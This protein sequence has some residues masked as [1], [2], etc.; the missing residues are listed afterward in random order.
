MK[1]AIC[2]L[3][4]STLLTLVCCEQSDILT[5][6]EPDAAL[7]LNSIGYNSQVWKARVTAVRGILDEG[8]VVG[9]KN[10]SVKIYENGMLMESLS[11]TDL[12]ND[13]ISGQP[14]VGTTK[15]KP[16]KTYKVV[17]EAPGYPSITSEF[18][19]PDSIPVDFFEVKELG[20][21]TDF[22]GGYPPGSTNM[23]FTVRFTDPPGENY[24]ELYAAGVGDSIY[25]DSFSTR[26]YYTF[27]LTFID[28]AYQR[29][30]ET[31][32][33]EVLAFDDSFFD[34]RSVQFELSTY[35]VN[36]E[37]GWSIPDNYTIYIRNL[38]KEYYQY[39][40]TT[41]LQR[42]TA[43][44]PYAQPVLIENNIKGGYGIFG[45]LTESSKLIPPPHK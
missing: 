22:P 38:S 41:E 5:L 35:R 30:S 2:I 3:S 11:D 10:A 9:I 21:R 6:P 39:L 44:D 18:V 37:P 28:P 29:A 27:P 12:P 25:V 8:D 33:S 34:G 45:G 43:N 40:K 32:N 19:Q 26:I 16:G 7:A 36:P 1:R 42:K 31:L 4:I 17:A 15:P 14:Y 20:Q 23:Q 24:Y 13:Y